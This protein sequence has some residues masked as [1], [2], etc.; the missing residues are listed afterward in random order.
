MTCLS[1]MVLLTGIDSQVAE[2][3]FVAMVLH[4]VEIWT[5]VV[6]LDA[7]VLV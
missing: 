2:N 3:D 7:A 5:L 4:G 6:M 1:L